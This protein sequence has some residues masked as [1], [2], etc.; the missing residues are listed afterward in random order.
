M[1]IQHHDLVR[2]VGIQLVLLVCKN[3]NKN[4]RTVVSV[5]Y[6]HSTPW[7]SY[8]MAEDE[9]DCLVRSLGGDSESLLVRQ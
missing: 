7:V 9:I 1:R 6:I 2:N 8:V 4:V 3:L 5:Q